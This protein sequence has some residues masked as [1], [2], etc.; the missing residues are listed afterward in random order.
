MASFREEIRQIP[1]LKITIP[2]VIGIVV[3]QELRFVWSFLFLLLI[4]SFLLVFLFR[5]ETLK[6]CATFLLLMTLGFSSSQAARPSRQLPRGE[7]I[8]TLLEVADG[9]RFTSSGRW[10]SSMAYVRAYRTMGDSLWSK[11][12]EKVV[13]YV[14]TTADL[15]VGQLFVASAYVNDLHRDSVLSY[16]RL[17]YSRGVTSLLFI[18]D[19]NVRDWNVGYVKSIE[20]GAR[21]IRNKISDRLQSRLPNRDDGAVLAAL[22]TGDRTHLTAQIKRRYQLAGA[23]HILALSGMHLSMI[24]IVLNLLLKPIVLLGRRSNIVKTIIILL[25]IWCY[26]YMSGLSLSVCRAAIMI[27]IAQLSLMS[28]SRASSYNSIFIA[29]FITLAIWPLALYDISFQLSYA[30]MISILFF[31]PRFIRWVR[32]PRYFGWLRNVVAV[33]LAAQIGAAPLIASSFGTVSAASLVINPIVALTTPLI[34]L[35]GSAVGVP[36]TDSI[37]ELLFKVHNGAIS[38]ADSWEWAGVEGVIFSPAYV[39]L[40]YML[41]LVIMLIIKFSDRCSCLSTLK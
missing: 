39:L 22:L 36:F 34:M 32:V 6:N 37:C 11:S 21:K 29:A 15:S 9:V 25:I 12:N 17:M 2:F 19:W 16:S 13:I 28:T 31:V 1:F 38:V 26:S 41:L 33:T 14:D 7:R 8:E 35:F 30:A 27:T 18:R 10:Q 40:S 3:S 24:F 23:S 20:Y 5:S 4:A